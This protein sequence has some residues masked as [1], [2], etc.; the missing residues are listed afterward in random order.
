MKILVSGLYFAFCENLDKVNRFVVEAITFP[1][2]TN[3][4]QINVKLYFIGSFIIAFSNMVE[5]Q[6]IINAINHI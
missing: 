5:L 3:H 4:A 1:G 6:K 2:C